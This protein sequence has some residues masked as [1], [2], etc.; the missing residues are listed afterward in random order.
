MEEKIKEPMMLTEFLV[1][2]EKTGEKYSGFIMC[3]ME[4]DFSYNEYVPSDMDIFE[5]LYNNPRKYK[6]ILSSSLAILKVEYS[7]INPAENL[8]LNMN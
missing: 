8:M 7:I 1:L 5:H 4:W 2:N 6:N 3:R